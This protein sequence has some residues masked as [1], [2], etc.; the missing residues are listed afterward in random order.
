MSGLAL[1]FWVFNKGN[2]FPDA[3]IEI[4]KK[5]HVASENI[6]LVI[7]LKEKLSKNS[8]LIKNAGADEGLEIE[9]N[10]V[11]SSGT[12]VETK[13]D[14]E[15][16]NGQEIEL[17]IYP[18]E[19]QF[20]PGKYTLDAIIK[21]E[22]GARELTQDFNWGVLAINT[23][24]SVY[25]PNETAKIYFGVL[26]E[27]GS[28]IC[29]A[30]LK[31]IIKKPDGE[32][33][34]LSS[35]NGLIKYGNDCHGDNI[36]DQPDYYS[37]YKLAEKGMYQLSLE[38][39]TENGRYQIEDYFEVKEG[40]P[41][42]VERIGPTRINPI[43]AYEVKLK[44]KANQDF[45]GKIIETVPSSFKLTDLSVGFVS[46]DPNGASRRT[47]YWEKVLKKG[48]MIELSYKF[49]APDISPEFFLLGLLKFENEKGSVFEESRYWQIASDASGD[50]I[51]FWD[52]DNGGTPA[53]W[54][55]LSCS[56][57]VFENR[58]PLASASA[59]TNGGGETHTPTTS[60]VTVSTPNNLT[61]KATGGGT[62]A[63][64]SSHTHDASSIT[65]TSGTDRPK[66]GSLA[67]ISKNGATSVPENAII[68]FDVAPSGDWVAYTDMDNSIVIASSSGI[69]Q[70]TAGGTDSHSH[71]VTVG[72]VPGTSIT[73]AA[74]KTTGSGALNTAATNHT[75][76]ITGTVNTDILSQ[77]PLHTA[78]R[79]GRC[80][81]VAGCS[82]IVGGEI[83]MFD[84]TPPSGWTT[85]S[86]SGG[87][88]DNAFIE[89]STS[90]SGV[91]SN[92]GSKTHTHSQLT[93]ESDA[94]S[95][96]TP[97][98]TNGSGIALGHTHTVTVNF[99]A[100]DHRPLFR[101]VVVAQKQVIA[102]VTGNAYSDE[103]TM[104]WTPCDNVTA[105]ISL[106]I[107]GGTAQ[108][109]SCDDTTGLYSFTDV[110][111][112]TNNPVSVFFNAT[113]SGA[114]V[115][116][117]ADATSNITLNPRLNRVWV[118][119]ETGI[120]NITNSNLDHCDSVSP[121]DCANV[122]YAVTSGAL[123]VEDG[124]ELHIESGKT[125]APG[126]NASVPN[127]HVVGT[128]TGVT[129]GTETLT[130][131][132]SGTGACTTDPGTIRPL[133][134]DGGTFTAS[135]ETK[136]T[137]TSTSSV[138]ATTYDDLHI[139]AAGPFQTISGTVTANDEFEVNPSA[140]VTLATNNSTLAVS[141]VA[142][143]SGTFT[144]GTG[145]KTFSGTFT[146][147]NGGVYTGAVSSTTTR[148]RGSA[149][150]LNS[151]STWTENS[152][153]VT[154]DRGGGLSTSW[155]DSNSTKQDMGVVVVAAN[156]GNTT[157]NLGSSLKATTVHINT[158]QTLSANGS[159][160]LTLLGNATPLNVN[161]TFTPSTGTIEYVPDAI[162]GVTLASVSYNNLTLNKTSNTFTADGNMTISG[163]GTP[164]VITAG[165]F[166]P[167]TFIFTYDSTSATNITQ[168]TYYDL[169][170]APSGAGGPT[171]TLGTDT[172]QTITVSN[173]MTVGGANA[174]TV[175]AN[176]N[177]PAL[178]V[179]GDFVIDSGDTFTASN[180][181]TFTIAGSWTSTGATFNNSSGT[182]TFDT[183]ATATFIGET[184]FHN[185][186]STV[187]G[188]TLQFTEAQTFGFAGGFTV[189]GA[190][191]D[192]MH[193]HSTTTTQWKLNLSGTAAVT[194]AHI[195]NSGCEA[196]TN[197]VSLD[198]TSTDGGNND[199]TC[200]IFP[201][202]DTSARL[203]GNLRLR[204]GVRF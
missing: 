186:V 112:A 72:T 195:D 124:I 39:T 138:E 70:I 173:D 194:Y 30:D 18:P 87:T 68:M 96:T 90:F 53:D 54:T 109:T 180:T 8:V 139:A 204:G 120:S 126:G 144:S 170:L 185:F 174:V 200:W 23:N 115:T 74:V 135:E 77:V 197:P 198:N 4:N 37:E 73:A 149:V 122:P 28:T 157:V 117:A 34:L 154:F 93:K 42:D 59:G 97:T 65:P 165:T 62:N 81:N 114:A 137:G 116:V 27:E 5:D 190:S 2:V 130:L 131:S 51:V 178:D 199:L 29:D 129:G 163:N 191:G 104:V 55:C 35:D 85:L 150:T 92:V 136:F 3:V 108:T 132:G 146:L 169:T 94:S 125:F 181:G 183:A 38:A 40:L 19:K 47:F 76:T 101:T 179:N 15:Q 141:G 172:G 177:D 45:A 48:Q 63:A 46:Q 147:R 67:M 192:K 58:F 145:T 98:A 66:F 86:G 171:Y 84:A 33:D 110:T 31:L 106:V 118:K 203:K 26:N 69:A 187:A 113:N 6:R 105:N 16:L 156:G 36:T 161:G 151:S 102:D 71:T 182:V 127:L 176:S 167:A 41:F 119:S 193:I 103:G 134:I 184:T 24:K 128:Y 152:E 12:N 9:T 202:N 83:A 78:V 155:T 88:F 107:N 99:N 17:T 75:H 49:D 158:S 123:T 100:I 189:T 44:L 50:V 159:N 188:K 25:K 22:D 64:A 80:T 164:L 111:V 21:T 60:S 175:T 140:T 32:E 133:C 148:F 79:L 11:H 166:D 162:T 91:S 196:G 13:I 43:A 153:A 82:I 121:G 57:G 14:A 95:T 10:L 160:T 89:A 168:A 7:N 52:G 61:E 201:P 142:S 20:M 56:G 1:A 143:I